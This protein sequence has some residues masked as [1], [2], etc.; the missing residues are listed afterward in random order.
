ML[1]IGAESEFADCESINDMVSQIICPV[2]DSISL[3]LAFGLV[4]GI[5]EKKSSM[6]LCTNKQLSR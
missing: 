2:F 6:M 5:F 3:F 1:E 4:K